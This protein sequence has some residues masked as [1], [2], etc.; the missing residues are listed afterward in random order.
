MDNGPRFP[1]ESGRGSDLRRSAEYLWVELCDC[2]WELTPTWFARQWLRWRLARLWKRAAALRAA[3]KDERTSARWRALEAAH[4]ALDHRRAS[5]RR[6]RT[7]Q[8]RLLRALMIAQLLY[9]LVS[10]YSGWLSA[11]EEVQRAFSLA[12]A[13]EL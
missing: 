13:V 1:N 10:S 12:V 11:I 9:G 6:T 8:E 3:A 7:W 2:W 4:T 5:L